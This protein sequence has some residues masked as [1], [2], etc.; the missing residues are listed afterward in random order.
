[1]IG[2]LFRS[3]RN[4]TSTTE[5]VILLRPLVVNDGDWPQLVKDSNDRIDDLARKG[6]LQ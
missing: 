1:V 2:R 3:E 5:L 6:K 4:Q